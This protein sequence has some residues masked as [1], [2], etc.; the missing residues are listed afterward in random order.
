[1]L[2]LVIPIY[3]NSENI[4]HLLPE[5][6]RLFDKLE[7]NLEVVFVVDGSPDDSHARLEEVLPRQKFR[8]QLL[9]LSRNFGSFAAI[10]AGLTVGR[11]ERLAVMAADLQEP[12]DLIVEFDRVLRGGSADVVVGQRTGRAD[13]WLTRVFSFV[14]WAVYRRVIQREVPPGGVDVFGCSDKVRREIVALDETHSSLV[15]LLL[16]TGFRRAVVPY[17]RRPRL[18]GRS[19]WT[20]GKKLK[21]LMD[22]VFAFTDLPVRLLLLAGTM[23]LVISVIYGTVVFVAKVFFSIPVPGYAALVILILFFGGLNS[24]GLGLI[25]SYVWRTFENSKGRPNYI[26]MSKEIFD[27]NACP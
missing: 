21:Y 11:G 4:P 6:A 14:F 22:S 13:P 23:G 20:F 25:G 16:W 7:G 15:G 27:G 2:S 19:S 26:V 5:L 12:P 24:L 3:K 1:M 18:V 9:A 17:Q 8:S 10:R